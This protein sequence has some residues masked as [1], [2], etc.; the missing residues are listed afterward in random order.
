MDTAKAGGGRSI[1]S[2]TRK[3]E[4]VSAE[5]PLQAALSNARLIRF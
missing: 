2:K 1:P 4:Q 3:N 5:N